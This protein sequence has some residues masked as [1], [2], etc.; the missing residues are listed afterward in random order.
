MRGHHRRAGVAG[1]DHRA[2]TVAGHQLR[3]HANRRPRPAPQ[4]RRRRIGHPDHVRRVDDV[5]RKLTPVGMTRERRLA[6]SP[7]ADERHWHIELARGGDRTVHDRRRRV[8]TAHGIDGYAHTGTD[9]D[10]TG[11]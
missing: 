10:E 3:R 9:A 7:R 8:V 6:A 2:A 5:E 11:R 1:A 4:R